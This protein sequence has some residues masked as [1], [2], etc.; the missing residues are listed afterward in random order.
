M[1]TISIVFGLIILLFCGWIVSRLTSRY[2]QQK[3]DLRFHLWLTSE[4]VGR[5]SDAPINT[6]IN[7]SELCETAKAEGFLINADSAEWVILKD[8]YQTITDSVIA[9]DT[10]SFQYLQSVIEDYLGLSPQNETASSDVKLGQILGYAQRA[11]TIFVAENGRGVSDHSTMYYSPS[12]YQQ[13]CVSDFR[14]W[15]THEGVCRL[16]DAP[17]GG[18]SDVVEYCESAVQDG[19]LIRSSF[20]DWVFLKELYQKVV[21]Y[22]KTAGCCTFLRLISVFNEQRN[23]LES[24]SESA[25]SAEMKVKQLVNHALSSESFIMIA[26]KDDSN[27]LLMTR[28]AYQQISNELKNALQKQTLFMETT[29]D[30]IFADNLLHFGLTE[31]LSPKSSVLLRSYLKEDWL[32]SIQRDSAKIY[33]SV[34]LLGEAEQLLNNRGSLTASEL[35]ESIKD[36]RRAFDLATRAEIAQVVLDK[37]CQDEKAIKSAENY[38]E[39]AFSTVYISNALFKQL[40]ERMLILGRS[41][42]TNLSSSI[43]DGSPSRPALLKSESAKD[44]AWKIASNVVKKLI[45]DG[46]V[47]DTGYRSPLKSDRVDVLAKTERQG[48]KKR[49]EK[50]EEKGEPL[51]EATVQVPGQASRHMEVEWPSSM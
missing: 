21:E 25:S 8:L 12:A 29:A 9:A 14:A 34:S 30:E 39:I 13:K 10:C 40:E 26:S 11:G 51:Y 24:R 18:L 16:A 2:R 42:V 35:V 4:G 1:A 6:N 36:D 22:I 5:I 27:F 15:V 23:P 17:T 7:A 33:Y 49:L 37:L 20:P 45:E 46:K 48:K 44:M 38:I 31:R 19:F 3:E 28:Q 32:F 41:T 50:G 43:A 47:R